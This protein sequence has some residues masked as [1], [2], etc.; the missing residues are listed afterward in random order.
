MPSDEERYVLDTDASESSIGAVLS[1][2][3]NREERAIA[4]DSRTYNKTGAELLY[5]KEGT[6]CRRLLCQTV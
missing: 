1:Q 5:N 4:Y 2:V 3:Q 6:S